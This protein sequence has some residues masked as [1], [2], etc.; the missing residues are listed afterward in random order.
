MLKLYTVDK[1]SKNLCC[2][3]YG[4]LPIFIEVGTT[5]QPPVTKS[6]VK[7]GLDFHLSFWVVLFRRIDHSRK[8]HNIPQCSLFVT[9]KFCISIVFIFSWE[10]K[11]PQEKL[12]TML[13]Q[14]FAE[15][16]QEHYGMLWYFW[17][18][19]LS[20]TSQAKSSKPATAVQ[21][22]KIFFPIVPLLTSAIDVSDEIIAKLSTIDATRESRMAMQNFRIGWKISNKFEAEKLI[23]SLKMI[24]RIRKNTDSESVSHLRPLW[25]THFLICKIIYIEWFCITHE[26]HYLPFIAKSLQVN[27]TINEI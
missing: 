8:Y 19:Q 4:F 20:L 12:K 9:P 5:I 26:K 2:V 7:V 25:I 13:M 3:G 14:S 6:E 11:W 21:I 17:S 15:T 24:T 22:C 18:G 16:N 10:L 23:Y 1:V 27:K